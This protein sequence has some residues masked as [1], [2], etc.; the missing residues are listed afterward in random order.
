MN[1]L[2][3]K[4]INRFTLLQTFPISFGILIFVTSVFHFK[5][6]F[7]KLMVIK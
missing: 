2:D 3:F 4:K 5:K 6:D 7:S 1:F